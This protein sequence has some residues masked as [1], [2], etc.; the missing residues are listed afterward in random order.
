MPAVSCFSNF[1]LK[2][3]MLI[4]VMVVVLFYDFVVM[5]TCVG[6][7]AIR[8][9]FGFIIKLWMLTRSVAKCQEF[10]ESNPKERWLVYGRCLMVFPWLHIFEWF[11]ADQYSQ[12]DCTCEF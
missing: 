4:K 7:M 9:V 12:P 1:V 10:N 2:K 8:N 6:H 11:L 3:K 5:F